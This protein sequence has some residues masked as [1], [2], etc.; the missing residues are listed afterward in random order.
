M[1]NVNL[2]IDSMLDFANARRADVVNCPMY[3]EELKIKKEYQ[4]LTDGRRVRNGSLESAI[5]YFNALELAGVGVPTVYVERGSI[6]LYTYNAEM[7]VQRL[8][9]RQEKYRRRYVY[10]GAKFTKDLDEQVK[11]RRES[12]IYR[13][14]CNV[15]V[16]FGFDVDG[17][18]SLI[19]NHVPIPINIETTKNYLL[20]GRISQ[21]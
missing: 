3:T 9:Y 7:E 15:C 19:D 8:T 16:I 20:T 17:D 1:P 12:D 11:K 14:H 2:M 18:V 10:G 6:A 4:R 21:F 13:A 5:A